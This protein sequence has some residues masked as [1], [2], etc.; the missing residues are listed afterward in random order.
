M[1]RRK[2]GLS[3]YDGLPGSYAPEQTFNDA[4]QQSLFAE[5]IRWFPRSPFLD[6]FRLADN[7]R[8]NCAQGAIVVTNIHEVGRLI[9]KS[10]E[11]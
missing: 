4:G 8:T 1:L 2:I 11:Q 6:S 9:P 7:A 3:S 10:A 5:I